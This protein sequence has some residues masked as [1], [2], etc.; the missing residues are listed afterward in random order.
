MAAC[1]T[2]TCPRLPVQVLSTRIQ[3]PVRVP[4]SGPGDDKAGPGRPG[5]IAQL[6]EHLSGRQEVPGSSPGRSTPGRGLVGT[7]CPPPRLQEQRTSY[8][9]GTLVVKTAP[10][11]AAENRDSAL[12]VHLLSIMS[13]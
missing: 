10:G 11:R 3:G 6:V 1:L 9:T 5:L 8:V 2:L 12:L 4:S 7:P 13:L